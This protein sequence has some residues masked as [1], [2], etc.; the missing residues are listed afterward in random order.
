MLNLSICV[1]LK[2]KDGQ[3]LRRFKWREKEFGIFN[4]IDLKTWMDGVPDGLLS[5]GSRKVAYPMLVAEK[6]G[7]EAAML[8]FSMTLGF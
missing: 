4:Q 5:W 8:G 2:S 6:A 1:D 7:K 3:Q